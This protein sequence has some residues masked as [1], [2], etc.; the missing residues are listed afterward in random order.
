MT[1]YFFEIECRMSLSYKMKLKFVSNNSLKKMSK[2]FHI[3]RYNT[4]ATIV[5]A[6]QNRFSIIKRNDC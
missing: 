5:K 3:N 6:E 1:F 4:E 2:K